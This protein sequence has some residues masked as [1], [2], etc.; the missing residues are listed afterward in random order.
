MSSSDHLSAQL[1]ENRE[2]DKNER[3]ASPAQ[4]PVQS[5]GNLEKSCSDKG[6]AL[7]AVTDDISYFLN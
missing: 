4:G 5:P 7:P 3:P 6:A 2:G 1:A